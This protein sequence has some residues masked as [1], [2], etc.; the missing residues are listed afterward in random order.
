MKGPAFLSE[1]VGGLL[2]EI[3]QR[4]GQRACM[5]GEHAHADAMVRASAWPWRRGRG[6]RTLAYS[7]IAMAREYR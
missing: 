2:R 3:G 7:G 1:A 4:S 5:G 6:S